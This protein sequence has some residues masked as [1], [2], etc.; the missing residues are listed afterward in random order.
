MMPTSRHETGRILAGGVVAGIVGGL[1][2][3]AMLVALAAANG[4][5][6]WTPLKGAAA[7]LL[8]ERA[9]MPGVDFGAIAA[10]V[11]VHLL[12]SILWAIPFALIVDGLPRAATVVA[13]G[14]WGVLVFIG[15]Y[16][17]ALPLVGM[18]LTVRAGAVA[19][20]LLEHVVFGIA[21]GIGYVPYQRPRTGPIP[22]PT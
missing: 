5:D 11:G 7:P 16:Y 6:A 17:V 18:G 13:G 15:M 2:L 1:V 10:G 12:V 22:R 19:I 21:V 20:P 8:G 3:A 14:F 4:K 9:S